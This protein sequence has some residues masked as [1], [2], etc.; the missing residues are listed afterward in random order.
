[1]SLGKLSLIFVLLINGYLPNISVGL[2][3]LSI[4]DISMPS[5]KD[6]FFLIINFQLDIREPGKCLS[7]KMKLII[8]Q[9]EDLIGKFIN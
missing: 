8:V 6:L 9:I 2:L 1:M 4:A 7:L 5:K 3:A